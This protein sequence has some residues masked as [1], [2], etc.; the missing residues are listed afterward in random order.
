M[1]FTWVLLL[2]KRVGE[3]SSTVMASTRENDGNSTDGI[4]GGDRDK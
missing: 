3:C 2:P 1:K 4:R